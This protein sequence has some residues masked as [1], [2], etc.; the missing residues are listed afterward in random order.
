MLCSIDRTGQNYNLKIII[1][2]LYVII[3][4]TAVNIYLPYIFFK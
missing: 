2:V 1:I 3:P 4:V